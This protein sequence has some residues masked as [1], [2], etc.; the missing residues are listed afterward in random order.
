MKVVVYQ[1][2]YKYKSSGLT[3]FLDVLFVSRMRYLASDLVYE[4][5]P[6]E[7]IIKAVKDAMAIMDNSGIILEE[8]FR[9][10]Y[11]QL[12]GSLFKDFRMTQKG[13]FLVLLNLP[14]G[15]EF[16]HKIQLSFCEMLE[17]R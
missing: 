15:S 2:K 6:K 13:W 7:D 4:G 9:P 11:T 1:K 8:H 16:A 17:G 12:K 14:P 10:V 3:D 5:V